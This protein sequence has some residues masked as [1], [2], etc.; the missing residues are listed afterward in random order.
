MICVAPP[1]PT[2]TKSPGRLFHLKHRRREADHHSEHT[3][4]D[5][6]DEAAH[7]TEDVS[8]GRSKAYLND[9]LAKSEWGSRMNQFTVIWDAVPTMEEL[10][11]YGELDET[12]GTRMCRKLF[13]AVVVW[14][15]LANS[16][17][18]AL[19]TKSEQKKAALKGLGPM[20]RMG[21]V[22]DD[23]D[24][25]QLQT[26]D[27]R[28][29]HGSTSRSSSTSRIRAS[30][31]HSLRKLRSKRSMAVFAPSREI[32]EPEPVPQMPNVTGEDAQ[33]VEAGENYVAAS[34]SPKRQQPR[35][36]PAI[37]RLISQ[38]CATAVRRTLGAFGDDRY[39]ESTGR[40][41]R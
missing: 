28:S 2:T 8:R 10:E 14:D 21:V 3:L 7:R 9:F 5:Q 31:Q 39:A 26:R 6:R 35:S 20:L 23:K 16:L 38:N 25:E 15:E 37:P 1:P 34:S 12:E 4:L 24:A 22:G 29:R 13:R 33:Q 18:K 40:R 30:S 17:W 19:R 27:R 41:D 32:D 36:R 11:R